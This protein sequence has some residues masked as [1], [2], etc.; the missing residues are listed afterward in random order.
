MKDNESLEA[1]LFLNTLQKGVWALGIVGWCFGLC[2]R[3]TVAL[4]DG[5]LSAIDLV[6]LFTAC[7]FFV[8]WLLLKPSKA[9]PKGAIQHSSSLLE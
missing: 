3:T 9:N 4:S 2:E 7:F 8:C 5:Y 1:T 6:L